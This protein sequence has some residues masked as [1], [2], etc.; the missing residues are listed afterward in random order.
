MNKNYLRNRFLVVNAIIGIV[1]ILIVSRIS[2]DRNDNFGQERVLAAEIMQKSIN[3]VSA[4]CQKNNINTDKI[5]DPYLS[6]L[7]APEMSEITTTI[8]HL[9]AKRS[10]IN[11]NFAAL[12]VE[13][14]REAGVEKGDTIAIG[15]SG[16]F[17]A[18]LIASIS[19]AKAMEVHPN[20]ILSLGSSSFGANN[21]DFNLIDIYNI[22]LKNEIIDTKPVAVSFGGEKDIG[23]E[24]EKEVIEKLKRAIE[25]FGS[26]F[27]YEPNLSK[28]V[29]LR[30]NFYTDGS[31]TKIKAFINTG[32]SY[33]N[34]GISPLSLKLM[35]GLILE[36]KMPEQEKA[37]MIFEMLDRKIP[38]IHLLFIKGICQKYNLKWDAATVPSFNRES[39]NVKRNST[40]IKIISIVYLIY[41]GIV[42]GIYIS[43]YKFLL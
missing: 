43:R 5:L 39:I 25:D 21:L 27:I 41:I 26:P 11:P 10:T 12:I 34:M 24:F 35:P 33:S 36:A 13:L 42:L 40:L 20:I 6:G 38:V 37:G 28:N 18:L 14:L 7:I 32:G 22:L 31:K 17:P 8:G 30:K 29:L 4:H 16:S 1:L 19:A 15:N 9:E 23:E 3:L 2:V